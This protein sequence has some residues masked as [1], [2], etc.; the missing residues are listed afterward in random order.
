MGR[1][2]ATE[3]KGFCMTFD[4]GYSISCQWGAVNY[5]ENYPR[6]F[7]PDYRVGEEMHKSIHTCADCEVLIRK[8]GVK[9]PVTAD[10]VEKLGMSADEYGCMYNV[11]PDEVAKIIAHLV[12]L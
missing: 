6:K 7:E 2:A 9:D 12:T 1:F 10:V 4:N 3:N 8:K 11:T 5:C